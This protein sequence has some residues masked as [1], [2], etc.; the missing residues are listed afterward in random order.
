MKRPCGCKA[1]RGMGKILAAVA[2]AEIDSIDR[3][4]NTAKLCAYAG[5][6]PELTPAVEKFTE[7]LYSRAATNGCNGHLSKRPGSR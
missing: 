4:S 1:F 7:V 2:A 6:V 5:L 3:F